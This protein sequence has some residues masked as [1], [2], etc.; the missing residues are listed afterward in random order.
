M[1]QSFFDTVF[2]IVGRCLSNVGLI[3]LNPQIQKN[4]HKSGKVQDCGGQYW[5]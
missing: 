4:S 5:L 1:P 3:Y 2:K